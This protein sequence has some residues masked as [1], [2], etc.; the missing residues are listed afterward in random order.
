MFRAEVGDSISCAVI[1]VSDTRNIE[2]DKSGQLIKE[3]LQQFHHQVIFYKI[4]PDE[5]DIIRQTVEKLIHREEVEI[6]IITGGTGIS[7]RDV[8]IE[9]IKPLLEKELPGFGELFR[10][11]SYQYD[12]G[13]AAILSRATS[14]VANKRVIFSLPGSVRAVQ[15]AMEKIILAE[16]GHLMA[17]VHKHRKDS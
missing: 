4:I 3:L 14:G 15:L 1:T 5:Q 6:V 7:E 10:Y 12:I 17:E 16:L 13:T 9:A 8:T 11:L 2:T